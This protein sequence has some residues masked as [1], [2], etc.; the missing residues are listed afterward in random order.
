MPTLL[1]ERKAI[2][3][4]PRAKVPEGPPGSETV[5]RHQGRVGELG[6]SHV[7]A[8][9]EGKAEQTGQTKEDA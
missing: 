7:L 3:E 5:A 4:E 1:K 9:R 8:R 2:P 6:R